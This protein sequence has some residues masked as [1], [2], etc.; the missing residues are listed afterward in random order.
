MKGTAIGSRR[1]VYMKK[2]KLVVHVVG[3]ESV[4]A[5]RLGL[6][7]MAIGMASNP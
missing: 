2:L 6:D 1:P 5:L 3:R 4:F 7:V